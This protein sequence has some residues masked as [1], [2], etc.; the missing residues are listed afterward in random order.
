MN[1]HSKLIQNWLLTCLTLVFLIIIIGGLTRLTGSGL[2]ITEWEVFKGILPP[3]SENEWKEYFFKYQQIPEF[4]QVNYDMDLQGFKQIFWLEYIHRV[5][6]R[7]IGLAYILPLIYFS[8]KGHV[9]KQK[10]QLWSIAILICVQG[11]MG[12][13][14][15]KSGLTERID[16]SQYRLAAH[17]TLASIIYGL[18]FWNY[19]KLTEVQKFPCSKMQSSTA[20]I[21]IGLTY[22]MIFLGA[23][24]AGTNAGLAY[25]TYPLMDGDIIPNGLNNL[26]PWW[27]NIFENIT[28]IQFNHRVGAILLALLVIIFAYLNKSKI[29]LLLLAIT[30]V[31]FILGVSTLLHSVPLTLAILHQGFAFILLTCAIYSC[32]KLKSVK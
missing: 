9:S 4:T 19:L 29:A 32:A 14:M 2:S 25:N 20:K 10:L 26:Q 11:F 6:G 17:L 1:S 13:Y 12:W 21:I 24:M 18:I 27:L 30:T 16:V 5:L 15:V 7:I 22:I 31:Q 3:L 8:I 28:T 23:L